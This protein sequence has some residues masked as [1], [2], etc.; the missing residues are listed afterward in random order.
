MTHL[1]D[2]DGS[3]LRSKKSKRSFVGTWRLESFVLSSTRRLPPVLFP[4]TLS[5]GRES[6]A[7]FPIYKDNARAR[8]S[9]VTL[10]LRDR[11]H[12]S[13]DFSEFTFVSSA[14]IRV[15]PTEHSERVFQG[16]KSE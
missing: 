16:G 2:F 8:F 13:H 10:K 4:F 7:S 6:L 3:L 15:L 11:S 1:K 12:D 5:F 14:S 9:V